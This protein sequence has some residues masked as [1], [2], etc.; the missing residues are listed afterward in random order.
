MKGIL[1]VTGFLENFQVT[2]FRP[3]HEMVGDCFKSMPWPDVSS[4]KRVKWP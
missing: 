3:S 4:N 2:Q 1:N